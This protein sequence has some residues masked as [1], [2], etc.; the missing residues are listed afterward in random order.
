V[1]DDDGI[2]TE[3]EGDFR[4]FEIEDGEHHTYAAESAWEALREH[5]QNMEPDEDAEFTITMLEPRKAHSILTMDDPW[6][7]ELPGGFTRTDEPDI[8]ERISA[9]A[10]A[11]AAWAEAS[12]KGPQNLGSTLI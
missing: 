7:G 12:K 8:G 2:W 10:A 1:C 3:Y 11:W 4:L 9:P 5:Q 6:E